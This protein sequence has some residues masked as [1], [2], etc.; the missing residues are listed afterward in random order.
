MREVDI[1]LERDDGMIAAIEVKASAT[2][3]ASD[4]SGPRALAE[5]CGDRFAFGVVLYD[6]TDVVPSGDR[7]AAGNA[8]RA[9]L[10]IC[11][12]VSIPMAEV[13]AL[14]NLTE[15]LAEL[16]G[17]APDDL[18]PDA[19]VA[20]DPPLADVP[21]GLPGREHLGLRRLGL[22]PE[23]GDPVLT[24]LTGGVSSDIWKVE[25]GGAVFCVKRALAKL[26][27]LGVDV[28]RETVAITAVRALQA[29]A[30]IHI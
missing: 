27:P 14:Y 18:P 16:G 24:P 26:K 5:A 10:E 22:V 7:P 29:L 17:P 23:A 8:Y 2:V 9:C 6:S 12:D 19:L 11:Y 21:L 20:H 30:L 3:K 4:F 28:D 25:A 15:A 13:R 1:V